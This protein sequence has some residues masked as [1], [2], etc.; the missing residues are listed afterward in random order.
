MKINPK[1]YV[2]I[3]SI[4]ASPF[5]TYFEIYEMLKLEEDG[6]H[7]I[8]QIYIDG[9]FY[10][11]KSDIDW[12]DLP[13]EKFEEII[14]VVERLSDEWVDF[15]RPFDQ[16]FSKATWEELLEKL[17][18]FNKAWGYFIRLIDVPIYCAHH[19]EEKMLKAVLDAGLTEL[20]FDA[21]THPLYNTYHNRRHKDAILLKIGKITKEE[22]KNN[23]KHSQQ[24]IFQF[25]PVDDKFIND[26]LN[27]IS[28]PEKELKE[29][30]EQHK[31]AEKKF[32]AVYD[33]LSP[34]LQKK[35][36]LIQASIRI[37]DY[38]FEKAVMGIYYLQKFLHEIAKRLGLTYEKMIYMTTEE[39]MMKRIPKELDQRMVRYGF[40][41]DGIVVGKEADE[42]YDVFNK[43]S[44]EKEVRGKGV[45][46]GVVR[47]TAKVVMSK[48][49][50]SKINKGDIIVCEITTPD[51][52]HALKK[53]SAIVSNIGGFTSHSAIVAREFGIPCVAGTGNGTLVFKDGNQI[54]VDAN[55]GIVKK[56][57]KGK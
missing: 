36:D 1:D 13:D 33:R 30:I 19:M 28:D 43:N 48:E 40:T 7:N 12:Y 4:K 23:W 8:E 35:A 52:L 54:E 27:H 55:K 32:K 38:R 39:I 2:K 42:L 56:I 50:L 41:K 29:L 37:R 16:E 51:Y 6:Y 18:D 49:E 11:K 24:L 5:H 26:Q 9:Q 15:C 10:F 45:S 21:L 14:K 22:F 46:L 20:D 44:D 53:V 47:G 31:E 25:H 3:F 34:N 17:M 57:Q